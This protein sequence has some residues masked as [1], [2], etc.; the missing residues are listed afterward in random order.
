MK[1]I[2]GTNLFLERNEKFEKITDKKYYIA[3]DKKFFIQEINLT[4]IFIYGK[5]RYKKIILNKINA[6]FK[7]DFL[8]ED[9][10]DLFIDFEFNNFKFDFKNS[11]CQTIYMYLYR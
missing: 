4:H 7:K 5:A 2:K 9:S 1:V 10:E 8:D 3:L 11:N 6:I